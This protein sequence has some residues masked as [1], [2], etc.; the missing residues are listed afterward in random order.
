MHASR[1]TNYHSDMWLDKT[2]DTQLRLMA[3][4]YCKGKKRQ[5]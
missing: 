5:R 2:K 1:V 4:S 3:G